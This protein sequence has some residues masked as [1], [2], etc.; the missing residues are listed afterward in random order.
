ME[1]T[2]TIDFC[3]SLEIHGAMILRFIDVF[4]RGA[5]E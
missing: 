3:E 2:N 1:K 5:D 4:G